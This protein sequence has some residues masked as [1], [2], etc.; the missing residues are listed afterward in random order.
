MPRS[1]AA[2]PCTS[3]H[4]CASSGSASS[5]GSAGACAPGGAAASA[6]RATAVSAGAARAAVAARAAASFTRAAVRLRFVDLAA[7]NVGEERAVRERDGE[8]RKRTQRGDGSKRLHVS[9]SS[10]VKSGS[11]FPAISRVC[12]GFGRPQ[13]GA[14]QLGVA[15]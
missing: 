15:L 9:T 7:I 12:K 5:S 10:L 6:A 11:I 13:S 4:A 3:A 2:G 8:Q 14:C 1:G